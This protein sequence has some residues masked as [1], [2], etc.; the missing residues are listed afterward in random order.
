MILELLYS[1]IEQVARGIPVWKISLPCAIHTDM[2]GLHGIQLLTFR[3]E[4]CL[5]LLDEID[6][7]ED[8]VTRLGLVIAGMVDPHTQLFLDKPFNPVLG[9][10]IVCK[11]E[12][13]SFK[14]EQVSHHPP[15]TAVEIQGPSFQ[16]YAP[17]GIGIDGFKTIKPGFNKIDIQFPDCYLTFCSNSGKKLRWQNIG[18]RIE[19]LIG[20]RATYHYGPIEIEDASG[21]RF[22]GSI[23]NLFIKG[24]IVDEDG[25]VIHWVSGNLKEGVYLDNGKTWILP[26]SNVPIEVSYETSTLNDPMFSDNVWKYVF[27]CLRSH[28]KDYKNAD[29]AKE[30]VEN[31]QRERA[32]KSV[33]QPRFTSLH[34]LEE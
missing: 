11:S 18:Y 10:F 7:C 2:S 30:Q 12:R 28:P 13:F 5:S 27:K 14:A 6:G 8:A 9:E 3:N 34:L 22:I 26:V 16:L 29:I 32:T 15:V 20:R 31:E 21:I 23:N 17:G 19:G 4:Q 24:K 25:K 1:V 33:Y